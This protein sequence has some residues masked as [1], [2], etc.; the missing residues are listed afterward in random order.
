[1]ADYDYSSEGF[2]FITICC[3]DRENYFGKISAGKII[4]SDIGKKASEFWLEIPLHFNHVKLDAFVV[5]PNH[6]HGIIIL[7][8]PDTGTRHGVSPQSPDVM[9]TGSCH[10]MTQYRR[11]TNQFSKPIEGSVSVIINQYKAT[12]K[13]WCNGNGYGS[14]QWQSRFWDNILT[15]FDDIERI[16]EYIRLNPL[17]WNSE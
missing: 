14:F 15:N 2:Y 13:R 4:L 5:M 9:T 3:K 12:L 16:R 6:I 17:K 7:K 11:K 1:M 8:Y 10:G